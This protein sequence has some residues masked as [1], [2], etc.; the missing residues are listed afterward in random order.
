MRISVIGLIAVGCIG[1]LLGNACSSPPPP[2]PRP[3]GYHRIELPTKRT[4][5][6]FSNEVCNFTFEYPDFGEVSQNRKDSCWVDVYFPRFECKWHITYHDI[7]ESGRAWDAH[8]E[9]HRTLVYKHSQKATLIQPDQLKAPQGYG[10][11][12]E[13][14]GNVGNPAQVFFSSLDDR[15]V[16]MT[17]FYF[18]TATKN[19][20]LQPI[21]DFMKEELR[22]MASSVEWK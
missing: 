14:Y 11:L 10:T 2:R 3:Y 7:E 19:D 13:I 6:R 8:F 17:S 1:L 21:I 20:S 12:Y 16:V 9:E 18:N 5:T 4:Y 15:Q 22:H